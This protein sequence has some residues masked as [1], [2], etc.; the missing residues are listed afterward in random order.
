MFSKLVNLGTLIFNGRQ[1]CTC[2]KYPQN[3]EIYAT[4]ELQVR[5]TKPFV[6]I[7]EIQVR[8]CQKFCLKEIDKFTDIS[9]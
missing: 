1:P 4:V 5:I 7:L 6:Y 9:F 8:T 2:H 3:I